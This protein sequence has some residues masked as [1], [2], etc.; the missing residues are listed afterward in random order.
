MHIRSKH[1]PDFHRATNTK[2][3]YIF[4][5]PSGQTIDFTENSQSLLKSGEKIVP[6]KEKLDPERLYCPYQGCDISRTDRTGVYS[7]IRERHY[8]ELPLLKVTARRVNI[9]KT[10][11]G[12]IMNFSEN[13]QDL[14]KEGDKII[15]EL[16]RGE[17]CCPYQNCDSRRKRQHELYSH[18]RER[19]DPEFPRMPARA[20]TYYTIK[21]SS[22]DDIEFNESSANMLK[23]NEKIVVKKELHQQDSQRF[24]CPY[25]GCDSSSIYTTGVIGHI[26][27]RHF[28]KLPQKL[29]ELNKS[30]F[31]KTASGQRLTFDVQSKNLLATGDTIVVDKFTKRKRI[32][33]G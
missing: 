29:G 8:S 25:Q 24:Y 16:E 13:E 4:K 26:R 28:S 10:P 5:T 20:A 22:G 3:T 14:L 27:D 2:I 9:L 12:K 21:N 6:E 23:P 15:A 30:Y 31:L 17:F 1:Y 11:A 7:H 33:T 18:I 32:R 19:H